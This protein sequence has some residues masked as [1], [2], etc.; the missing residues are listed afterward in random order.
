MVSR[1]E[2]P[3]AGSLKFKWLASTKETPIPDYPPLPTHALRSVSN[4]VLYSLFRLKG[5]S[6]GAWLLE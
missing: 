6:S 4:M 1:N 3:A 2:A 5:K